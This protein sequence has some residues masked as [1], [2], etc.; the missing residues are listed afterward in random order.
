MVRPWNEF[1]VSMHPLSKDGKLFEPQCKD[2]LKRLHQMIGDETVP[3]EI[4][5]SYR[6]SIN[7]QVAWS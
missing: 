1:V 7:D 5:S 4:L 3:I 2:L 6:W